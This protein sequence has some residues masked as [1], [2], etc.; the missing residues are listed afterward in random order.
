MAII[1]FKKSVPMMVFKSL[2]VFRRV[3]VEMPMPQH[4]TDN[5]A[6]S[7]VPVEKKGIDFDK[8]GTHLKALVKDAKSRG[9]SHNRDSPPQVF[10]A[11]KRE[12]TS[13]HIIHESTNRAD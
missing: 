6:P 12:G 4:V 5:A 8:K 2:K 3:R 13:A 10:K 7:L 9:S 11:G 1:A